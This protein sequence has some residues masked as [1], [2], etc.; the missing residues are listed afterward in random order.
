MKILFN[1]QNLVT[2]VAKFVII[3]AFLSQASIL[4]AKQVTKEQSLNI[5]KQF[6]S[7]KRTSKVFK[8]KAATAPEFKLDYI[9]TDA[10][11]ALNGR[12]L[13][14]A[15][16]DST[17]YYYVYNIGDKQGFVIVSGDDN[18]APILGYSFIGKF[19]PTKIPVNVKY[20]M[21]NY[22]N[23]IAQISNKEHLR[24][25]PLKISDNDTLVPV[26]P[27]VQTMWG[28]EDPFNRSIPVIG[29]LEERPVVG[30]GTTAMAQILKYYEWP[31]HGTGSYGYNVQSNG[32][33][34][35]SADFGHA[36][37][38]W[39]NMLNEY[40]I[41][42]DDAPENISAVSQLMYHCGVSVG[43]EFGIS[44]TKSYSSNFIQ[45]FRDH[46]RYKNSLKYLT[47]TSYT[48]SEWLHIIQEE[49]KSS[50]P[51]LFCGG[52]KDSR[53]AFVADG[54]DR[55]G[56]IHLNYGWWGIFDGYYLISTLDSVAGNTTYNN[57][58]TILVG[59]E[60]DR[61]DT[62][63]LNYRF[64]RMDSA[65]SG[66]PQKRGS[67]LKIG[68]EAIEGTGNAFSGKAGLAMFKN[69]EIIEIVDSSTVYIKPNSV[70]HGNGN[71]TMANQETYYQNWGMIYRQF[72]FHEDYLLPNGTYQLKPVFKID[73]TNI[74]RP[75]I[76]DQGSL[77]SYPSFIEVKLNDS[78]QINYT[79]SK[80]IHSDKPGVVSSALTP[81]DN[82]QLKRLV[83]DGF[84]EQKDLIRI[85]QLT[86]LE[87]LDIKNVQIVESDLGYIAS[88]DMI[89][90][91]ALITA[92]A[93]HC[94]KNTFYDYTFCNSTIKTINLPDSLV[95]I[96]KYC[97]YNAY[98]TSIKLP[99]NL[100]E[101][102]DSA[103][104]YCRLT[105]IKLP[106]NLISI[107]TSA[108]QGC[109]SLTDI[110]FPSQVNIIKKNAF[111]YASN[112]LN[113]SVFCKTPP[114]LS[115]SFL[116]TANIHVLK[117]SYSL[118]KNSSLWKTSIIVGDLQPR[119]FRSVYNNVPGML[120]SL[121]SDVD[122]NQI[123]SLTI[124]GNLDHTDFQFI[125]D[126]LTSLT[127]L[128]LEDANITNGQLPDEAFY[129]GTNSLL[130]EIKIPN[131][132]TIIGRFAFKNC[133]GIT[134]LYIPEY[135]TQIQPGAFYGCEKLNSFVLKGSNFTIKDSILFSKDEKK[136]IACP[137]AK[138]A[139]VLNL[140]TTIESIESYAF[141]GCKN[142][143]VAELKQNEKYSYISGL[144]EIGEN[145]FQGAS[146]LRA[147]LLPATLKKIGKYAFVDCIN[148][149]R[150]ISE[151]NNSQFFEC[152]SIFSAVD[153][154]LDPFVKVPTNAIENYK[155]AKA[156]KMFS[157][158]SDTTITL[159]IYNA[160]A[161]KL[162]Y[163]SPVYKYTVNRL[164]I[165]GYIDNF[166]E[167][168]IRNNSFSLIE[169][170]LSNL[171]SNITSYLTSTPGLKKIILPQ[172][173]NTI[174]DYF[175]QYHR[176]LT[177][178]V[179]FDN[180]L[181]IGSSAFIGCEHLKKI[182]MPKYLQ[183]IGDN[184][185]CY[186]DSL[187]DI[188]LPASLKTIG[189]SSF[190]G[191]WSIMHLFVPDSV[192]SI[193]NNAFSGCININYARLPISL[194][195]IGNYLFKNA[196]CL[197][198]I[199]I[200]NP[201]PLDISNVIGV[202]D[203]VDTFACILEV[204]PGSKSRYMN[205][206]QWK[207]FHCI[208]DGEYDLS[209][210]VTTTAGKLTSKISSNNLVCL[211]SLVVH[212]EIDA[213]DIAV[214][215][216]SMFNLINLD[217]SDTKIQS[218]EGDKGTV[219]QYYT[220]QSGVVPPHGFERKQDFNRTDSIVIEKN[221]IFGNQFKTSL[222][223][224]RKIIL[225]NNTIKIDTCAFSYNHLT[226][227]D[228]PYSVKCISKRAFYPTA[229]LM[230]FDDIPENMEII[231]DSVF[232]GN[233]FK[234]INLP[235]T[236]ISIGNT[237]LSACFTVDSLSIPS[238]LMYIGKNALPKVIKQI[239]VSQDNKYFSVIDGALYDKSYSVIYKVPTSLKG[240]FI[241][242]SSVSRID[243]FAFVDCKELTSVTI[244]NSVRS[245]GNSAFNYCT[246]LTSVNIPNSV[247]SIGNSAFHYCT[248]LTSIHAFP[249]SPVDLSSSSYAF[250]KVNNT[251]CA[252][253]VPAGSKN[254]YQIAYI[255]KD[256]SNILEMTDTATPNL[257]DTNISLYLNPQT[258]TIVISEIDG[259]AT[260][261]LFDMNGRQLLL[262]QVVDNEPVSIGSLPQGLY[263]VTLI[264]AEGTVKR[265]I[266][267]K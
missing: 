40:S 215:R 87:Y 246:G 207:S 243:D 204:P 165:S 185:F 93:I 37:Y 101:I 47:H 115:S 208:V 179:C 249:T 31:V 252:L 222:P 205:A 200:E 56:Y 267:K 78:I 54:Y 263:I 163:D 27:L 1:L 253:Y 162:K 29:D 130:T 140:G 229:G 176:T 137:P 94:P 67:L 5:A 120:Y 59:I 206:N 49:I 118:Y 248:G 203:M 201:L 22:K 106:E 223:F 45:A 88:S 226:S 53:H 219:N 108:F 138:K 181:S 198:K 212:G 38:D 220:Y 83:V 259:K 30:C 13:A 146:N 70:W 155:S 69:G 7:E 237:A 159:K 232:F 175:F 77:T 257:N 241:I 79:F 160:I 116:T 135:V 189:N 145:A 142:L 95:S 148:L 24:M 35:Y 122:L 52:D 3:V 172:N 11:K 34:A 127:S 12:A 91:E 90:G 15:M 43:A 21:D 247:T 89:A 147:L 98:I 81:T 16:T 8:V 157:N 84:V 240:D 102:P 41:I 169:L 96:G 250:Y 2:S 260:L 66:T 124:Q 171:N 6:Y 61:S 71:F 242:L 186:C 197:R 86:N 213:R 183:S 4:F 182:D 28:Q 153:E 10:P 117:D 109:S 209:D 193:G 26:D 161:G 42:G 17:A 158:I 85:N 202:F 58:Q 210:T 141:Q 170:D 234:T 164:I 238:T 217:L 131:N 264:K 231:E 191:C 128:D 261:K 228:I 133:T 239:D 68:F 125:R 134:R 194:T 107:G 51:V 63:S 236:L 187:E 82:Y 129:K 184:A 111:L 211:Q 225:P 180:I 254:K 168:K 218:Y 132:T 25:S 149:N 174:P 227:I 64:L 100:T 256:F 245:I 110:L 235:K 150:I 97:F 55:N 199:K 23:Q 143:I 32:Q 20:M 50:R 230:T 33:Y 258:N 48:D 99:D 190:G 251:E 262:K 39:A 214:I 233:V 72:Q 192:C 14:P 139:T 216:D 178:V 36:T 9:S 224:L 112:L 167:G 114:T 156:W 113:I 188:S 136:L 173:M 154:D 103:F 196:S 46:F 62:L 166:D 152:D 80:T 221:N 74:W 44:G 244:P 76:C 119:V 60:P 75:A 123:N 144:I 265:K 18:T 195:S 126:K 104:M 121:F 65:F 92:R 19:D 255:W 57:A 151:A 177:Q 105:D 266:M 73:G